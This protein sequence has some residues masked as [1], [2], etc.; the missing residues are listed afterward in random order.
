MNTL[1]LKLSEVLR[2]EMEINGATN[3][4]TGETI[5]HGFIKQNLG[6]LLKYELKELCDFLVNERKKIDSL[7]EGLIEKYGEKN[8]ENGWV[9][10][11]FDEKYDENNESIVERKFSENYLKFEEE[12]LKLLEKEVDVNYPEITLEELKMAG[13]TSD[14]YE[15]LFKLVKK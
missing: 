14:N 13:R 4:S 15:I 10:R 11:M 7:R 1:K 9:V 3:N 2:L 5:F 8:D 12:Y 6:I